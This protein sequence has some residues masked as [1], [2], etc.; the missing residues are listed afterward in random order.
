L[1]NTATTD[2]DTVVNLTHHSYFNLRGHGNILGHFVQI[3]A[4]TFTP[5][6]STLI[7]TGKV[8]PVKDTPFDFR[9]PTTIG[10][11][12]NTDDDQIRFAKGYDHNWIFGRSGDEL[13]SQANVY[14]P[15]T[16]R[17]LEVLSTEPGM[18]FYSGNYLNGLLAGK[19]S[20]KYRQHD[21]FCME[22]QH[23]PDS[24]NQPEFPSTI[25]KPG[26]LYRNTIVYRFSTK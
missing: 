11:R 24:P 23:F 25:L 1:E 2:A 13:L 21:G 5:V 7:P 20:C 4:D 10:A 14:E 8:H 15:V 12:L 26:Q 6:D 18:Q 19:R 16:G 3:H 17:V 9:E 22:P